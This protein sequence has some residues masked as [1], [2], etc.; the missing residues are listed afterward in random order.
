MRCI[1]K[2]IS[3]LGPKLGPRSS[4]TSR[5]T[6]TGNHRHSTL[7]YLTPLEAHRAA[8]LN[9]ADETLAAKLNTELMSKEL[10]TAH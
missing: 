4:S 10:D 3:R 9:Q 2:Q 1:T 7:D 8:K 6:T 5:F